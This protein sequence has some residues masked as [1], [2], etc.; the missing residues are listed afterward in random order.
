MAPI[1]SI[2]PM[3]ARCDNDRTS[4]PAAVRPAP[5]RGNV[6]TP[7]RTAMHRF[8]TVEFFRRCGHA[9]R[10]ADRHRIGE[11]WH[12]RGNAKPSRDRERYYNLAH[13]RLPSSHLLTN[14][15]F[16]TLC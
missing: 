2:R 14:A 12:G 10:T 15:V 7:A 13:S 3:D 1:E 5:T 8:K 4:P 11:L 16:F 6:M 9:A